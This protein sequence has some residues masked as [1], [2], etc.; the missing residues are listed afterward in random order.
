VL[1][2][3]GYPN[4]VRALATVKLIEALQAE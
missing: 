2:N 4:P 3:R 1:A